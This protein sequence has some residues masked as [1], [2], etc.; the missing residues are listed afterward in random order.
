VK[1]PPTRRTWIHTSCAV[2]SACTFVR[3]G[4]TL[5]IDP[6]GVLQMN[7]ARGRLPA[8]LFLAIVLVAIVALLAGYGIPVGVGALVGLALGAIA[9]VVGVL[10]LMRGPGRSIHLGGHSWSSFDTTGAPSPTSVVDMHVLMDVLAVD[11]G[12]I[13]SILPVLSTVEAAGL[14]IQLVAIEMHEAG[15]SISFGV[16]AQPGG[17]PPLP[18]VKVSVSDDHGTPY[19]ALGQ[20]QG[21]GPGRLRYEVTVIPAIPLV[22]RRLS[23]QI[24]GFLDPFGGGRRPMAGPW[25]FNVI[26]P[27]TIR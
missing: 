7:E 22:S 16:R 5:S 23:V 10:W 11:L 3:S 9:G 13:H 8:L 4:S 2:V 17:L 26:L 21:G 18:I 14:E 19:R 1:S 12:P 25:T 6:W 20:G 27:T 24:D 15:A